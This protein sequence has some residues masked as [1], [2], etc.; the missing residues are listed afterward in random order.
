[1]F[2]R[3]LYQLRLEA[4][5]ERVLQYDY[6][7]NPALLI[8]SNCS[9]THCSDVTWNA[10]ISIWRARGEERISSSDKVVNGVC[11][12]RTMP[13]CFALGRSSLIISR[14]LPRDP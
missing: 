10:L 5:Y 1:V 2:D 7:F 14:R 4:E 12:F 6:S 9:F 13:I 3:E 11:G 8:I